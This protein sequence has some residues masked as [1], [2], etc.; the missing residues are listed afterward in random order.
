MECEHA[1]EVH[2]PDART[3]RERTARDPGPMEWFVPQARTVRRVQPLRETQRNVRSQR[4]NEVG[5]DNELDRIAALHHDQP[6]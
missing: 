4:G 5:K 6:C 1:D 2:R 3:H